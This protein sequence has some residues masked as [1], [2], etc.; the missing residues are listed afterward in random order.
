MQDKRAARIAIAVMEVVFV[1]LLHKQVQTIA[2][3]AEDTLFIG[4]R[5]VTHLQKQ[6]NLEICV[7]KVTVDL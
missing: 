3:L 6:W 2:D 4:K 1:V 7:M 5:I